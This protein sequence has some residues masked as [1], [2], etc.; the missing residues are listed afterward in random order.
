VIRLAVLEDVATLE[1]LIE[2]S[3]RTLQAADYSPA[4]IEG[5]LG[6][7]FGVDRQLIRDG[8]YYVIELD[9]GI[10][11]CGGWSRRRTLFG[12][13]HV[14][15]KDDALL[16]SA[17]EAAR[18]RAFFVHPGFARRGVGSQ[19]LHACE[20]AAADA[21]FRNLELVAT[22]TGEALYRKGG[23]E[24][25]RRFEVSL[26]NGE[27]LPVIHMEK[28]ILKRASAQLTIES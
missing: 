12:S 13:D 17:T 2:Q 19:I 15:G 11:A 14:T 20:Q 7:V 27:K 22:L 23:F 10:V 3:V 6:V 5:S 4:Q 8:T 1:A 25:T 21:G 18:I 16:D 28:G 26:A 24:P 9:G